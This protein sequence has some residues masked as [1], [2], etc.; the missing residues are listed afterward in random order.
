MLKLKQRRPR[1]LAKNHLLS[2]LHSI[3]KSTV[4]IKFTKLLIGMN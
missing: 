2:F 3:D 4:P 1:S